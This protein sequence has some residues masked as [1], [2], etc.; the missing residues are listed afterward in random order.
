[1][2]VGGKKEC[3]LNEREKKVMGNEMWE[4]EILFRKKEMD[5]IIR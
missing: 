3:W 4:R 5:K 2:E 1:M